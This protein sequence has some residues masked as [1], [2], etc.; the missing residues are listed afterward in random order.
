MPWVVVVVVCAR[1]LCAVV[2]WVGW[3]LQRSGQAVP[4]GGGGSSGLGLPLEPGRPGPES[5]GGHR[6]P[7]VELPGRNHLPRDKSA[8]DDGWAFRR[9]WQ[10][11]RV[12]VGVG[13]D[14]P[15][16][17]GC[18]RAGGW[19]GRRRRRRPS[20][21]STSPSRLRGPPPRSLPL[22]LPNTRRGFQPQKWHGLPKWPKTAA[23][24]APSKI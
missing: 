10:S 16:G 24:F 22:D 18:S 13:G 4:E 7:R 17:G 23:G 3:H 21:W 19:P 8:A 5:K 2:W 6:R 14:S 20:P 1:A 15:R 11:R 12:H 9:H